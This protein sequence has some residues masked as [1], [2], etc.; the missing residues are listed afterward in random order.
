MCDVIIA[1]SMTYY[2]RLVL[3]L[4][5]FYFLSFNFRDD[6]AFPTEFENVLEINPADGSQTYAFGYWNGHID[7]YNFFPLLASEV[8]W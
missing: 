3:I 6:T 2:V 1:A 4:A 7:W 8:W 5:P